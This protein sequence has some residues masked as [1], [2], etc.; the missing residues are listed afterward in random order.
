MIMSK[1]EEAISALSACE[2]W[3]EL[4]AEMEEEVGQNATLLCGLQRM[5]CQGG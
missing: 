3:D 2:D 5:G 1:L 4:Q